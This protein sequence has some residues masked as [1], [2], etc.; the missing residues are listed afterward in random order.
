MSPDVRLFPDFLY[1]GLR[2]T[3]L[4][5]RLP[6]RPIERPIYIYV[7][8]ALHDTRERGTILHNHAGGFTLLKKDTNTTK[9]TNSVKMEYQSCNLCLTLFKQNL[10][11][12][13]RVTF[14]TL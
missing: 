2:R 6:G 13:R 11:I 3:H 4:V 7:D 9:R 8:P 12:N 14:F 1:T 5:Y 10:Q